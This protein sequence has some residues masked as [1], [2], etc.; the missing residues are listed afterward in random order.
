MSGY[1][2][3]LAFTTIL[4][5]RGVIRKKLISIVFLAAVAAFIGGCGGGE[6]ATVSSEDEADEQGVAE[7]TTE[8]A[9]ESTPS[10]GDPVAVGDVQ[11]TVTKAEWSDVLV[12]KFGDEEGTFAILNVDFS[13]NSNQ[14]I[15]LATPLLTL[16]DSEGREFEPDINLN[17]F[18][19][20]PEENMFIGKVEPSTSKEGMII[21]PIE[22]DS[23]GLKFRVGEAKFAS[24]QTRDIDLGTL[25]KAY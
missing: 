5:G 16:V 11:W 15:R 13:N 10:V 8:P 19:V 12:S 4:E 17:F 1:N 20:Y 2:R 18:H 9:E 21:F 25:S 6:Q 3:D 23:S 14:D 22:P 24:N 7:Q